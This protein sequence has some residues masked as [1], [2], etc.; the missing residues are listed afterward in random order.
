V[1]VP[2]MLLTKS[3]LLGESHEEED[4]KRCREQRAE[5]IRSCDRTCC[6][7]VIRSDREVKHDHDVENDD[8][9]TQPSETLV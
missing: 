8:T 2:S 5:M 1:S 4:V 3:L 6:T 9:L 7:K